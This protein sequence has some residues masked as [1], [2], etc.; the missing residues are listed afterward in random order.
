MWPS[1][2]GSLLVDASMRQLVSVRRM[3]SAQTSCPSM[4]STTAPSPQASVDG[5]GVARRRPQA[6]RPMI[7]ANA[8]RPTRGALDGTSREVAAVVGTIA[9]MKTTVVG[10][11]AA[12][13]G[14]QRTRLPWLLSATQ[15][16][17]VVSMPP[18][19]SRH[20]RESESM[21]RDVLASKRTYYPCRSSNPLPYYKLSTDWT[22]T[23]R[24]RG[25]DSRR[26]GNTG[27]S[28]DP[29]W[30]H[31]VGGVQGRCFDS[32]SRSRTA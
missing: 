32:S 14:V 4:D 9:H 7:A 30:R 16:A 26:R 31:R 1:S 10:A 22:D 21:N 3:T 24:E 19:S 23:N 15:T 17:R 2:G 29:P 6:N 8:A 18:P 25:A 27:Y 5:A 20:R 28:R 11:P 12:R 13:S